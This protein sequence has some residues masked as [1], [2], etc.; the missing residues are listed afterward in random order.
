MY[1]DI[2]P[3]TRRR[4]PRRCEK[5]DHR[6]SAAKRQPSTAREPTREYRGCSVPPEVH[7]LAF[8][9]DPTAEVDRLL[10]LCGEHGRRPRSALE[11]GCGSGR[12]LKPLSDRIGDDVEGLELS[13]AQASFSA[14]RS[15]RV[16]HVGDMTRLALGRTYDLIHA[17]ANTLRHVLDDA[18]LQGLWHGVRTHL[19]PGG[20]F[21]A[22]LEFGRDYAAGQV[23]RPSGWEIQHGPIAVRGQWS[24]LA[25]PDPQSGRVPIEWRFERRS[26]SG[27]EA[28]SESFELRTDEAAAFVGLAA[29]GGMR[30]AG[31][32]ENRE[33]YLLE[34]QAEKFTGR[35]LVVMSGD[36]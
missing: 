33:P 6:V 36:G 15:G 3:F 9:W 24:V 10:F 29:A 1:S 14:E 5:E 11:L 23:G 30:L 21:V 17:S 12:L 22:D 16:V 31:L 26:A 2:H 34:R 4:S 13:A 28:W 35:G 7:A 20:L 8:A 27:C 25:R 18:D 32:Y 19:S